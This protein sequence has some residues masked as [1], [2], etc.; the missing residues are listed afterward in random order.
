MN[1]KIAV[2]ISLLFIASTF[3]VASITAPPVNYV[4][5]DPSQYSIDKPVFQAGEV[6]TIRVKQPNSAGLGWSGDSFST[7]GWYS[8]GDG[9]NE[10]KVNASVAGEVYMHPCSPNSY[11]FSMFSNC[12]ACSES[13]PCNEFSKTSF[14]VGETFSFEGGLEEP[15]CSILEIDDY[16]LDGYFDGS[17]VNLGHF[18]L[19]DYKEGVLTFRAVSPGTSEFVLS[20]NSPD[21]QCLKR[22]QITVA[23]RALPMDRIMKILEKNKE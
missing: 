22:V 11:Q 8:T 19:V 5:C 13:Y 3:G 1:K 17:P 18:Q 14:K 21:G 23:P 10:I 15:Y 9:W 6:I 2:L 20:C 12:P 4:P 7:T 16:Y